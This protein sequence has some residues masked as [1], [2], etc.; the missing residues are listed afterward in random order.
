M[1]DFAYKNRKRRPMATR[2]NPIDEDHA[3]NVR[4]RLFLFMMM[5][6]AVAA[7]ITYPG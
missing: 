2:I 1:K 7:F 5:V 4:L 6:P 3:W